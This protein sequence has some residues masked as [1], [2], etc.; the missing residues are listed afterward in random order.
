MY[1]GRLWYYIPF[2]WCLVHNIFYYARFSLH[3]TP[4]WFQRHL[5]CSE[6]QSTLTPWLSSAWPWPGSCDALSHIQHFAPTLPTGVVEVASLS[7]LSTSVSPPFTSQFKP[8]RSMKE[9]EVTLIQVIRSPTVIGWLLPPTQAGLYPP[10]H[11]SDWA[12]H[13]ICHCV[14]TLPS[15]GL[16]LLS[17]PEWQCVVMC[18]L[19]SLPPSTQKVTK[20]N[21]IVRQGWIQMTEYCISSFWTKS[22]H[23]D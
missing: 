12:Y 21:W 17:H 20:E 5:S 6:S 19:R 23:L 7:L 15:V 13:P 22:F 10:S 9:V 4:L 1:R 3:N 2:W 16:C 11:P 8:T 14:P 18:T